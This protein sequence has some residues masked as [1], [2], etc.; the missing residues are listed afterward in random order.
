MTHPYKYFCQDVLMTPGTKM[1]TLS[2]IVSLFKMNF[3]FNYKYVLN[4]L[5]DTDTIFLF[6]SSAI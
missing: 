1:L 4:I 2:N 6:L 5:K 3:E